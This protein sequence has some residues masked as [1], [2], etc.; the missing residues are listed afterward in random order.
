MSG[1]GARDVAT[2]SEI[3]SIRVSW[4]CSLLQKLDATVA[5][6]FALFPVFMFKSK[7]QAWQLFHFWTERCNVLPLIEIA[8]GFLRALVW[9]WA[10]NHELKRVIMLRR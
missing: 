10:F 2:V 7:S 5:I 1:D 9:I 3:G 4:P 8:R 6:S